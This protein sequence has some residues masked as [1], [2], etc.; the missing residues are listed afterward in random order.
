MWTLFELCA[1]TK[2]IG[3][4]LSVCSLHS[5]KTRRFPS[6]PIGRSTCFGCG[7]AACVGNFN[8]DRNLPFPPD[9]VRFSGPPAGIRSTDE[10]PDEQKPP[11]RAGANASALLFYGVRLP[12]PRRPPR[13]NMPKTRHL[14]R[15]GARLGR[16]PRTAERAD[17]LMRKSYTGLRC[18]ITDSSAPAK[19]AVLRLLPRPPECFRSSTCGRVISFQAA[20]SATAK[21]STEH[22]RYAVYSKVGAL[23]R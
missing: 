3:A 17:G 13:M 6:T 10:P 22:L 21:R 5:E 8:G 2:K 16:Y 11:T 20:V 23:S 1:L 9:A 7:K 14:R 15:N 12:P 4:T 19:I 18:S